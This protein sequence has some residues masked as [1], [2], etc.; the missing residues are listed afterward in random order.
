M[1]TKQQEPKNEVGVI[2]V[3]LIIITIAILMLVGANK[4]KAQSNELYVGAGFEYNKFTYSGTSF[5][6]EGLMLNAGYRH[7]GHKHLGVDINVGFNQIINSY[8]VIQFDFLKINPS[9]VISANS[10]I[11]LNVGVSFMRVAT[12]MYNNIY[13]VQLYQPYLAPTIGLPIRIGAFTIKPEVLIATTSFV[14][15]L[16]NGYG[17]PKDSKCNTYL[18]GIY[19]LLYHKK[20]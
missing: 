2:T 19:Y 10:H 4:C 18:V 3:A 9:L 13:A 12:G 16:Q 17:F 7:V 5:N 20:N 15:P 6:Q 1:T 8:K 11:A 14:N